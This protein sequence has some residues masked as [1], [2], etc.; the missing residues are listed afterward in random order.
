MILYVYPTNTSLTVVLDDRAQVVDLQALARSQPE[1]PQE[2]AELATQ[3][4]VASPETAQALGV[5]PTA[6]MA[7]DYASAT[8]ASVVGTPCERSHHLCVSP[9]FAWGTQ[10][11][12][13]IV[14]L[15]DLRLVGAATWTEQGQSSRRRD[16]SEAALEDAALAP[17]CDT[18]QT[19]ERDGW[20]ASYQLTSSD[21]LELRDVAFQRRPLVAS[22]KVVD[23]HV[24]YAAGSGGPAGGILRHRGLPGLLLGGDHSLQPAQ[25]HGRGGRW[26]PAAHDLPLAELAPGLQLPVHLHGA[27]RRRRDADRPVGNEGRGCGIEGVYHPV[28]RIAPPAGDLGLLQTA[29]RPRYRR[30]A[31]RVAGGCGIGVS[32]RRGADNA[33]LGRRDAGLCLLE[34]GQARPRARATYRASAPAAGWISQQGPEAFVTPAE[35]MTDAAVIWYVPQITNAERARCWA[36]ME[37][38]AGILVPQIWPCGSGVRMQAA[39][40]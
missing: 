24:G 33:G 11:L 20:Q 25:R 32:C 37:V 38:R 6:A 36:D 10:A 8:K 23:W 19:L 30:R 7:L 15:T 12:W 29:P 5:T 13:M 39:T 9:V 28:L 27:L 4:A 26:L 1:I 22:V 16:V 14:D 2:L 35:P 21:G 31:S 40:P 3:I 34:R 17:L 18:P